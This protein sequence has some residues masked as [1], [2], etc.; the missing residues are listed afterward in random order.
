MH[1]LQ[2]SEAAIPP[3]R[4]ALE[5]DCAVVSTVAGATA[6]AQWGCVQE[7]AWNCRVRGGGSVVEKKTRKEYRESVEDEGGG[8]AKATWTP[9]HAFLT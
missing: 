2:P 7:M 3:Q 4:S 5:Y 1:R 6:A 8:G 9:M